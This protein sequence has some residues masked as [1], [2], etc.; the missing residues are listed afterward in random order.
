[1]AILAGGALLLASISTAAPQQGGSP[2]VISGTPIVGAVLTSSSFGA[3]ARYRWQSCPASANCVATPTFPDSNWTDVTGPSAAN[4]SY[5][6]K[7][8]DVGHYLRVAA[9]DVNTGTN[10]WSPSEPVGPIPPAAVASVP[11]G[12][13]PPSAQHGINLLV[14]P[15]G[16]VEVKLPGKK[17]FAPIEGLT[18]IPVGTVVDT[19]GS[20]VLLT[21]A[22]GEFGDTSLD[23]SIEFYGGLFRALQR[24]AANAPAVAKLVQKLA[25]A[26]GQ[27][28]QKASASSG[29]P[30]ATTSRKRRRRRVWG[31]GS[32]SYSTAGSGGTGSV[33]G[34]TWLTKDTCKGTFFKVTEGVG[35]TVTDF[36]K[37]KKI[38]LGPGESYFAKKKKK[39]K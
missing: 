29:G 28:G 20:K 39:K 23:Q 9:H 38:E 15:F 18:T 3:D 37:K 6:V 13:V 16:S 34:T 1:M 27:K 12:E 5:T 4:Q 21:A 10:A 14:V 8:S 35:I 33:R 30:V 11:P 25:C 32:G 24:K 19:R 31:S 26:K 7:L 17:R 36:K 2:P 22:T